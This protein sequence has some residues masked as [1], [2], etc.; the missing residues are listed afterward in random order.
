MIQKTDISV[1]CFDDRWVFVIVVMNKKQN[2]EEERDYGQ[3]A[4][5]TYTFLRSHFRRGDVN[6][7]LGS[8]KVQGVKSQFF[9]KRQKYA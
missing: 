7:V 1:L 4:L 2:L 6:M 5:A 3:R 8:V 9:S